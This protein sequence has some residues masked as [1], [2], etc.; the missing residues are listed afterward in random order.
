M[1]VRNHTLIAVKCDIAF[2]HRVE[3]GARPRSSAP[4]FNASR[5]RHSQS[6]WANTASHKHAEDSCCTTCDCAIVCVHSKGASHACD[7][8]GPIIE[9]A[10]VVTRCQERVTVD[11][12]LTRLALS[13]CCVVVAR[14]AAICDVGLD[15]AFPA[16]VS[17]LTRE[18]AVD[19]SARF[20][21]RMSVYY[22]ASAI[23]LTGVLSTK[24]FGTERDCRHD[25][26]MAIVRRARIILDVKSTIIASHIHGS[27]VALCKE[28]TLLRTGFPM[29]KCNRCGDS[30]HRT[31]NQHLSS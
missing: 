26:F 19:S 2:I 25:F 10:K 27:T 15:L 11:N 31:A 14:S 1:A 13:H 23:V 29:H 22:R 9:T 18:E 16:E 12:V 7:I 17:D 28:T 6:F 8:D 24:A 21:P 3:A 4:A 5:R 30:A 20:V